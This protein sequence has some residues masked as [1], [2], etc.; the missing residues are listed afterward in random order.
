MFG[1]KEAKLEFKRDV[2]CIKRPASLCSVET[3]GGGPGSKESH[4]KVSSIVKL[5]LSHTLIHCRVINRAG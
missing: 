4:L 1:L 3:L 2:R 5:D